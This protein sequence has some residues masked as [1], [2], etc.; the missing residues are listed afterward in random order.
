[1]RSTSTLARCRIAALLLAAGSAGLVAWLAPGWE[2]WAKP[3]SVAVSA[4]LVGLLLATLAALWRGSPRRRLIGAALLFVGSGLLALDIAGIRVG[5][6]SP[7]P[8]PYE[9]LLVAATGLAGVGVLLR[10]RFARWLGLAVG[11]AGAA[12]SAMNL[13]LWIA[14]GLVD[15]FA[16][17]LAAWTLGSVLALVTL[18]GRDV[19]AEDRLGPREEVWRTRDPL[20]FW[21][22]AATITAIGAAP[23]L[24]VYGFMQHGAVEALAVPAAVLAVYLAIAAALAGHGKVL[25]GVLLA[26]GALALGG[27]MAAAFALRPE[28]EGMRIPTFYLP[29]WLPA[30]AMGLGAGVALLR[31]ALRSPAGP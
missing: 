31:A 7:G 1:M 21:T 20:V 30:A 15:P 18:G 28:G 19:A 29:F 13:Q 8:V 12:S 6:M 10:R 5:A 9:I 2:M 24:L 17:T 3:T 23:M 11:A 26:I 22:R 14:A 27:M 16:W 25:G 4:G